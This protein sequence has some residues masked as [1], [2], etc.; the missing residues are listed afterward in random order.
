MQPRSQS[1]VGIAAAG[2]SSGAADFCSGMASSAPQGCLFHATPIG[3]KI[4]Y[5]LYLGEATVVA[6]PY[7]VGGAATASAA[8]IE[9]E[10]RYAVH[11]NQIELARRWRMSPR[12]LEANRSLGLPPKF[13][14]IGGRVVYRLTD[15]EAYEAAQLREKASDDR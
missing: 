13:L 9:H 12:S 10:R 1:W 7:A 2:K 4:D 8:Q 5:Q 15:I 6:T 3:H 14:K 11:L